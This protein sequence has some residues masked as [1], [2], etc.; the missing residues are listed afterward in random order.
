[1]KVTHRPPDLGSRLVL[2]A[3]LAAELLADVGAFARGLVRSVTTLRI[4]QRMRAGQLAIAE[5]MM[6]CRTHR[7]CRRRRDWR[8]PGQA[9]GPH[10]HSKRY[11]SGKPTFLRAESRG[12]P[13]VSARKLASGELRRGRRT[14]LI[15]AI[16][17]VA[18]VVIDGRE[19]NDVAA[20]EATKCALS[21]R[22]VQV[23]LWARQTRAKQ[24]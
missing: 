16:L 23:V 4:W 6:L 19:G 20:I 24:R 7:R 10:W 22:H 21:R 11:R 9:R 8:S 12:T 1:M 18:V 14:R 5:T 15:R 17:T 3:R 2:F 13:Q